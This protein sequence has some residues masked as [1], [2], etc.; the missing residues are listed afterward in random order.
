[1]SLRRRYSWKMTTMNNEAIAEEQ[2]LRLK[3]TTKIKYDAEPKRKK[4][5]GP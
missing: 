4:L 3:V 5:A 1:M 2:P